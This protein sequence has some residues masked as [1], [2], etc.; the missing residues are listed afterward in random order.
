MGHVRAAEIRPAESLSELATA[1]NAEHQ[2]GEADMESGFK[3]FQTAGLLLFKAKSECGHGNWLAW[4]KNNLKFGERR[5]QRYMALARARGADLDERWRVIC[6]NGETEADLSQPKYDVTSYS[7]GPENGGQYDNEPASQ[8][9]KSAQ[10]TKQTATPSR[11]AEP[12][13]P[14]RSKAPW[15]QPASPS[16]SSKP[17]ARERQEQEEFAEKVA[18]KYHPMP[19]DPTKAGRLT[20]PALTEFVTQLIGQFES[21]RDGLIAMRHHYGPGSPDWADT[22]VL[23]ERLMQTQRE[24]W[25]R[26]PG[27]N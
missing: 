17:T 25:K 11:S 22:C 6:G 9:A 5:A 27:K 7:A 23:I 1:I 24:C 10:P 19:A 2:A 26:E 13:P 16:P 3:R 15:A 12:S 14:V 4:V 20:G 21:G 18:D 8:P